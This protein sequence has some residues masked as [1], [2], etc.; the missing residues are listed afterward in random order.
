VYSDPGFAGENAVEKEVEVGV[1]G[2]GEVKFISS[3]F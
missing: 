2:V 1:E 3:P